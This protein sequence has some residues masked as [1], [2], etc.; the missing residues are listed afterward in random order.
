MALLCVYMYVCE[1][2][3]KLPEDIIRGKRWM[4]WEGGLVEGR[5]ERWWSCGVGL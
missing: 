4:E 3:R 1:G 2:K 5:E